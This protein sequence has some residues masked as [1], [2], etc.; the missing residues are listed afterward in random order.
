MK[1]AYGMGFIIHS[2]PGFR[3]LSLTTSVVRTLKLLK[4]ISGRSP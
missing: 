1:V 4:S 3:A 2:Y